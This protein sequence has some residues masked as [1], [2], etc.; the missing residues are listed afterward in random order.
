M[1]RSRQGRSTR[2][3]RPRNVSIRL[4][5]TGETRRLV[6]VDGAALGRI[7]KAAITTERC[8]TRCVVEI[9]GRLEGVVQF[10]LYVHRESPVYT[11]DGDLYLSRIKERT[12]ELCL[13]RCTVIDKG[14]VVQ[15]SNAGHLGSVGY[16]GE[17]NGCSLSFPPMILVWP[18]LG[19]G[20]AVRCMSF[21]CPSS[22]STPNEDIVVAVRY[23]ET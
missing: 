4:V 8:A 14:K 23:T 12:E 17:F 5:G 15:N 18:K 3:Q 20:G 19:D 2:A 13:Q 6:Q 16:C 11:L 21:H 22:L 9:S 7:R 1:G 10:C